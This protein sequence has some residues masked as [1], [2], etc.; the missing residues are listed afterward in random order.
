MNAG[1]MDLGRLRRGG[2]LGGLGGAVLVAHAERAC[3]LL[4]R[5]LAAKLVARLV[6]FD[7]ATA[8]QL[9]VGHAVALRAIRALATLDATLGLALGRADLQR[10][11]G[12]GG[13]F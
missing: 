3:R 13:F 9:V 7:F 5:F 1:F 6:G 2:A 12:L 10:L 8:P 4:A 11:G